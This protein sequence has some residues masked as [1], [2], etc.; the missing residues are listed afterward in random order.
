MDGGGVESG[1]SVVRRIRPRFLPLPRLRGM[2]LHAKPSPAAEAM[3]AVQQRT[4]SLLSLVAA[5]LFM[6]LISLV[7]A[8][9]ILVPRIEPVPVIAAYQSVAIDPVEPERQVVRQSHSRPRPAVSSAA[10]RTIVSQ[11]VS[12]LVIP[13]PEADAEVPGFEIGMADD[14]GE[15]AI[16]EGAGV[17]EGAPGGG[18]GTT[19]PGVGGLRGRLY[20]FKQTAAREPNRGYAGSQ[21]YVEIAGRVQKR[22]FADSVLEDFFR[23]PLELTLTHLAVPFT[24]AAAGPE[25]FGAQDLMQPSGWLAHYSGDLVVP[26]SGRYRF[27]GMG[28]DYLSVFIDGRLRLVACWPDIQPRMAGR[29]DAARESGMWASP[30]GGQK[31]VVGDWISLKEGQVVRM[32]LGIGERPGGM[33]GFVL[34][35]EREGAE[36]GR[37]AD[38]RPVLP[39]F[40][41]VPFA[42]ETVAGLKSKFGSYAFEWDDVPVFRTR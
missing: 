11:S 33:V 42:A 31:L 22:R 23:A 4:S 16:G 14:F 34:M 1:E 28:D 12:P 24:G 35:V 21:D 20:D 26:E 30:M 29:W 6:G 13:V 3:R 27:V 18:F 36:Y 40:T 25:Y 32:D 15:G 10:L 38:G 39:L 2:S 41:T 7:L 5:L 19:N 17:G 37:D 8:L 9:L